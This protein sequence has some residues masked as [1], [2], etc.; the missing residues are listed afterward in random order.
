MTE[1]KIKDSLYLDVYCKEA[2]KKK[3][4]RIKKEVNKASKELLPKD[5]SDVKYIISEIEEQL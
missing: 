2:I 4:N 3:I 1:N 5:D